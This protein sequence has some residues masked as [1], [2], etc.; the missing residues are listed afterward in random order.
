MSR[1]PLVHVPNGIYSV[2][3]KCNNNEF[4]FDAHEKFQ[5]Y[6]THLLRWKMRLGFKLYDICCM[7]NHV[8][9]MYVIPE[10]VTISAILQQVKGGFSRLYNAKFGRTGHFWRNKPFYRI[11]EDERYALH[12]CHYYHENPVRA[13]MVSHAS[14]WPYSGYRFHH[15]GDRSDLLGQLLD[16]IPGYSVQEWKKITAAGHVD[17][18]KLLK[19]QRNRFIGSDEFRRHMQRRPPSHLGTTSR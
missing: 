17:L 4:H 5:L 6:L 19:A 9:E 7:S 2:V 10:A 3:S 11:V 8:H 16:P 13:G 15:F 18:R 1:L 14:E 12:S